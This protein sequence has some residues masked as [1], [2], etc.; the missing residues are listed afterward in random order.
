MHALSQRTLVCTHIHAQAGVCMW[1]P[2]R[3]LDF[4]AVVSDSFGALVQGSGGGEG[5]Q[6]YTFHC[7]LVHCSCIFYPHLS[8][9]HM[10]IHTHYIQYIV[11]AANLICVVILQ[12][13][14]VSF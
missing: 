4:L 7:P 6:C 5:E 9:R 14:T 11:G 1:L 3:G 8:I 13:S 2:P 12:P 10:C